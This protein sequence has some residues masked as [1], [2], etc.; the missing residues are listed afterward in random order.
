MKF[1]TFAK[2]LRLLW[3]I[4]IFVFSEIYGWGQVSITALGVPV[5]QNFNGLSSTGTS[6]GWTD[7]STLPGW[8]ARTTATYP[9]GT[10]GTNDGSNFSNGLFSFGNGAASDRS[11]GYV[12]T[13]DESFFGFEGKGFI[14]WRLR[15]NSNT[16][17][18]GLTIS[19][20]GEQW[21]NS[22]D[23]GQTL[24][25]SYQ[26]GS[27]VNNLTSGSWIT[28]NTNFFTS[29]YSGSTVTTLDGNNSSYRAA[30]S[31]V[32]TLVLLPGQEIM[33]RWDDNQDYG[34]DILAIDDISITASGYPATPLA[35]SPTN[36]GSTSFRINWGIGLYATGYQLTLRDM[37]S[38]Q[39]IFINQFIDGQNTLH[40]DYLGATP[41][42]TYR[43]SIKS[44]NS[45][46]GLPSTASS[47]LVIT[48]T[49]SN[50]P[51]YIFYGQGGTSTLWNIPANWSSGIV[52]TNYNSTVIAANCY[53]NITDAVC[54]NMHI[55]DDIQLSI[56]PGN[57]L[58]VNGEISEG[59][60]N[61]LLKVESNGSGAANT[62]ILMH[63]NDAVNGIIERYV[64]GS[65]SDEVYQLVSV[66]IN[67]SITP[68]V[69]NVFLYSYLAYYN[70]AANNWTQMNTPTNNSIYTGRGYL[71]SEPTTMN[72]T[73]TFKG[74]LNNGTVNMTVSKDG[75]GWN[76]VGNPYP[77]TIDWNSSLGW[78]KTNIDNTIYVWDGINKRYATYNGVSG[79][80]GGSN[81]I[82][83]GEAFFVHANAVEP[84][85]TVNNVART[86]TQRIFLKDDSIQKDILRITAKTDD[87][88]DD[89]VIHLENEA[90]DNFDRF[91]DAY[92]LISMAGTT[93]PDIYTVDAE[94]VKYSINSVP[95]SGE[96]KV[97]D[98][99]FKY[100]KD[101]LVDLTA[102]ELESFTLLHPDLGILLEDKQTGTITALKL[103]PTYTF[104][105]STSD[106][107]MRFKIHMG[108]T[109]GIKETR[110]D[111]QKCSVYA[112]NSIINI[113]YEDFAN[114]HGVA[115]LFD[116]QG[117]LI[118]TFELDK[119][120][121][122]QEA[123]N[124]IK[125]IYIVRLAFADYT[126]THKIVVR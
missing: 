79:T 101:G 70:E 96:E 13:D 104:A 54:N 97:I 124:V 111:T 83:P 47:N 17:I 58:T 45:I 49:N 123:I 108:N 39:N 65:N 106:D 60:S 10:Y 63:G 69:S 87:L 36:V 7:N 24:K 53:V 20:I 82:A 51:D 125:G 66:P 100:G 90:T 46:S 75:G 11:F 42:H 99:A 8:Y 116:I 22:S 27:T 52:P 33:L 62:G 44:Y 32:I 15:N 67:T 2:S 73:Y 35:V 43:Y 113:K 16:T 23:G 9:I 18:T 48:Y 105:Y 112:I 88:T 61:S 41:G 64:V 77:S 6:T 98:L 26:S 25:L 56:G 4:G 59:N 30:V 37:T 92:N 76:L 110:S 78:T 120:G 95:Y 81:L 107:P 1:L 122:Q 14:G 71:T 34:D 21:R 12:S 85:L 72:E 38:S 117:R 93:V 121:N 74:R 84:S 118:K 29:P 114:Q 102:S 28:D 55:N 89:M 57:I 119:S 80:N 19:W 5:T 40:Y 103:N 86:S 91:Y 109:L 31:N 115:S 68:Q 50:E 126:E 94:N 3:L